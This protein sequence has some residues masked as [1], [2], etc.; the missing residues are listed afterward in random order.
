MKYLKLFEGFI[1][2]MD[3]L[4][5]SMYQDYLDNGQK[6]TELEKELNNRKNSFFNDAISLYK[7]YID[8]IKDLVVPLE[9]L[10]LKIMVEHENAYTNR[11]IQTINSNDFFTEKRYSLFVMKGDYDIRSLDELFEELEILEKELKKLELK[12][13]FYDEMNGQA[14]H[15]DSI[16][17]LKGWIDAKIKNGDSPNPSGGYLEIFIKKDE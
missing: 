11:L 10:G 17:E 5:K 9:D 12:M 3:K 1:T 15:N 16:S 6:K 14:D 2:D 4:S 8:V 7:K 13:S